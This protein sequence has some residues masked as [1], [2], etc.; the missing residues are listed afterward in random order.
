MYLAERDDDEF[1]KL[2]AIK[3][4]TKGMD[5]AELLRRF[6]RER[7][8]L[9][10]RDHPYIARLLDGGST[11]D[12]RPFLAMEYVQGTPITTYCDAGH[13]A[14]RQRIELFLKVCAAVQSAHQNLVVHRDL[15][16]SNILVDTEGTPKLLDFGIAKL[17]GPGDGGDVTVA[18][19]GS[20]MLTPQYAS[21]EQVMGGAIA[22]SADVYALGVILYELLAGVRP[23]DSPGATTSEILRAVC[24]DTP[25]RPSAASRKGGRGVL[26]ADE[27]DNI[28]LMALQKEPARRYGSV[29]EFASDLQRYLDGMPVKARKDTLTY[30]TRKFVRRHRTGAGRPSC[31]W[32]HSSQA[33]RYR[34]W[35]RCARS[36][37]STKSATWRTPYSTTSTIRFAICP[38]R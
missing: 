21:P 3:L 30:R 31:W 18:L 37:A 29:A 17:M 7:Q 16:P 36:A 11:L 33:S 15:K 13:L 1:R 6:R 24:E 20:P 38:A 4:V 28:I 5:T 12:G 22:T 14:T 23:F 32:Q 34:P 26:K 9:A 8:I 19:N 10:R 2:V 35:K 25:E 27:L